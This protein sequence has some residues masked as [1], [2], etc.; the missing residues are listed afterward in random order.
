MSTWIAFIFPSG[1]HGIML[2]SFFTLVF[3]AVPLNNTTFAH[4]HNDN[5]ENLLSFHKILQRR[6]YAVLTT[7]KYFTKAEQFTAQIIIPLVLHWI[8]LARACISSSLPDVEE[9]AFEEQFKYLIVTS[10]LLGELP[11]PNSSSST[12]ASSSNAMFRNSSNNTQNSLFNSIVPGMIV[13]GAATS[14]LLFIAS[15]LDMLPDYFSLTCLILASQGL[16]FFI[17]RRRH[18]NIRII[19]LLKYLTV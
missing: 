16:A 19:L 13:I 2:L 14:F 9:T 11:S 17:L 12:S 5:D 7:K 4:H 6:D 3:F 10:S 8:E 1:A 18:V 15:Y